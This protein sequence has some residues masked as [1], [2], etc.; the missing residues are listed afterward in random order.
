MSKPQGSV[1][2]NLTKR[3]KL[4]KGGM[5]NEMVA[6]LFILPPLVLFV[7]T[8]YVPILMGMFISFFDIDIVHLP[9]DFCGFDNYIRAFTDSKFYSSLWHNIKFMIYGLVMGFWPPILAALLIDEVRKG[10]TI[11]RVL[12]FIP[13]VAPGLAMTIIWK[14][15]W[16]PDYGFANY[17]LSLL[18][19][20]PRAWLNDPNLVYFCMHFS[21]LIIVGGMN[22]LIYLAALQNV[23]KE[24]YEAALIDGAG[25]LKRVRYITLPGIKGIISSMFLLN[26]TGVF[27]VLEAVLMWTDGGPYGKTETLLS[28]AYKQALNSLDYSYAI[29]MATIVFLITF[30]LTVFVRKLVSK[31]ED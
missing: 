31:V 24:Q 6:F 22:M 12:Y 21:T 15:F 3:H 8:K 28:Y 20:G 18:G 25:L 27:N 30:V 10:K 29:T 11:M 1:S 23:P 14:Y 2:R 17:L 13:A 16:N 5:R 19:M 7:L 4:T 9:G 26:F